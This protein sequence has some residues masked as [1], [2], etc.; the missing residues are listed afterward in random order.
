MTNF[1]PRILQLLALLGLLLAARFASAQGPGN[2]LAFD[3][4]DDY[5]RI[6]VPSDHDLTTEF[7][8]NTTQTGGGGAG[9]QWYAGQGIVDATMG[10]RSGSTNDFGISLVGSKVAF[11]IGN[12]EVTIQSTTAVNDGRWHHVAVTRS[13]SSG[14][15]RL[16]V[17]GQ[18]EAAGTGGTGRRND[19]YYLA[20]GGLANQLY[21]Y[22]NYN[23]YPYNLFR[24]RLDELRFFYREL[25]AAEVTATYKTIIPVPQAT[26]NAYRF[27]GYFAMEQGSTSGYAPVSTVDSGD[28]T[29]LQQITNTSGGYFGNGEYL[30]N[31]ALTSGNTTSNFVESYALVV[32]TAT[33][34]TGIGTAGFTAN[35]AASAI[36]TADSYVLDVATS[37]TFAAPTLVAGSPFALSGSTTSQALTGLSPA[38]TYYY[39]VRAEKASLSPQ[40]QGAYSNL[41]ATTTAGPSAY[42]PPGNA[43]AFDGTDDYVAGA[44]SQLPQG[45]AART[46]EAWVQTTSTTA[47]ICNYGTATTNQRA[48][49]MVSSGRLYYVG[50]FNDFPT[51]KAINDGRWH[52]VAATY[53]GT[54]LRLYVDG[55]IVGTNL[56][57]AF[58]TTGFGWRLGSRILADNSVGEQLNGRLDEVRVYNT[59][60]T[61]EQVQADMTSTSP[62]VPGSLVA[63]Y[64]CDQGTPGG[65]N[66]GFT[67]LPD[68][69][70][71]A[72]LGILTNFNLGNGNTTSN[73][74]SSYAMV[75]PR[76]GGAVLN[77]TGFTV[78]WTAPLIN[79]AAIPSLVDGY[80]LDVSASPA[81]ASAVAGSPFTISGYTTTS[82]VVSGLPSGTDYY[83]R[84]RATNASLGQGANSNVMAL[85]TIGTEARLT[86]LVPST[87]VL[88]PVLTTG[89]TSYT[90]YVPAGTS[91]FT[92]TPIASNNYASVVVDGT[93]VYAGSPTAALPVG[94]T[95]SIVVRSEDQQATTTYT[96]QSVVAPGYFRSAASGSWGSPATWESS[97]DNLSWAP[98][99]V[100]PAYQFGPTAT[101]RGGHT[102]T[103]A[104]AESLKTV[105]IESGGI[106]NTVAGQ[107]L[108]IPA[109][110]GVTVAAGGVLSIGQLSGADGVSGTSSNL[111]T[112]TLA[113]TLAVNGTLVLNLGAAANTPVSRGIN[114]TTTTIGPGGRLV[115]YAT[116]ANIALPAPTWQAGSTLEL[117]GGITNQSFS[118]TGTTATYSNVDINLSTLPVGTLT[119]GTPSV[120]AAT[121]VATITG[122]LRVV[123]T[124]LGTLR[125]FNVPSAT[126]ST[127]T[128]GAA[129]GSGGY[130]Q[131]AGT[132]V[133]GSFGSISTITS[134][135][136]NVRGSFQLNGG[137]F[138]AAQAAN[139]NTNTLRPNPLAVAGDFVVAS[140]ATFHLLSGAT[141]PT[142]AYTVGTVTLSGNFSN[143][144]TVS[145]GNTSAT[146]TGQKLSFAQ[147][148]GQT[149][150]NTGT[151]SGRVNALVAAGA[152]LDMGTSLFTGTG[153]FTT[154]GGAVVSTLRLGDPAGATTG[155]AA[156]GNI[157]S[158]GTRTFA[159]GT[160]YVLSGT[161]PQTLTSAFPAASLSSPNAHLVFDNPAGVTLGL[162]VN[163]AGM[164]Q[165]KQ[166]IVTSTATNLLTLGISTAYEGWLDATP[167]NTGRV[168]GPFRCWLS[169]ANGPREF[170]LVLGSLDRPARIDY[171]TAPTTG[172]TLTAEFVAE[173]AGDQGLPLTEG[174]LTVHKAA[175]GGFWR[176]IAANGLAGGSYTATFTFT[177]MQGVSSYAETLLLKRPDAAS[178]W[179]LLG[180]PVATTGSNT[181]PVLSRAGLTGFSDFTIGY[182]EAPL[183]V[184]LTGFTAEAE[185][186]AARLRWATASE[187]NSARFEI[188]RS[189]DGKRFEK[190]GEEQAQGSTARATAYTFLAPHTPMPSDPHTRYYRLRQVDLD[191][192][193]SYSPVRAVQLTTSPLHRLTVAP[194]P[195]RDQLR[196]TLDAPTALSGATLRLTDATGRVQLQR[197]V[198][199]P[200]GTSQLALPNLAA[201]APGLYVLH[202][203]VPGQPVQ[204]LKVVKE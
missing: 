19:P 157:Q 88:G 193:A 168:A 55:T 107:L 46:L 34:A 180:T 75:V 48:G 31:F 175:P 199:A 189:L 191:G 202:L 13:M 7:W 77:T 96:V 106:L 86:N 76:A 160:S 125:L 3:G 154:T 53:D 109:G 150:L 163:V 159:G 60:L 126:A 138:A 137:T 99:P 123:S 69:S 201:L 190:I 92:L 183:P 79:G 179:A 38:T 91:T 36:G 145:T 82:Q 127:L 111:G 15:M 196:L 27:I 188:E 23:L 153:T 148:G 184:E 165:L 103:V 64:N 18:L 115:Y 90:V 62:A 70:A 108:T 129:D 136:V 141:G 151:I 173:A 30:S 167:G 4:I 98:A 170:P 10:G 9:S 22:P 11:G 162:P 174:S 143:A 6:M 44:S 43:L 58:N 14:A 135:V 128:L 195:F 176:F 120:W 8:L 40:G 97:S 39:R 56:Q 104:A 105:T 147:A 61:E 37:A 57:P 140:G 178:P 121:A 110:A 29:A 67:T 72:A 49:L 194:N 203:A 186:R 169:T 119:V 181:A 28:N 41:M 94:G 81:F 5:V 47:V 78:Q 146:S 54:T 149:F 74:V 204:R 32:P 112:L 198:A 51:S 197:E 42:S 134:T 164:L 132:K 155:T 59:A 102:V 144:G 93:R 118:T 12:P 20:I 35:W 187:K 133:V 25:T 158:T 66:V 26:P 122:T 152:T 124:G 2:A 33:A 50:E 24:G 100:A 89:I 161:T 166:G 139:T 171:T 177:G 200:A 95:V 1:F 68:Q 182:N 101:V 87:G 85:H 142:L 172:G 21:Q 156:V 117:A 113:G 63:Y 71:S 130:V 45:N 84:V 65:A 114:T 83:V 192:T 16:Y 80:V 131:Q 185:G 116:A 52:H 17:D 73:Y